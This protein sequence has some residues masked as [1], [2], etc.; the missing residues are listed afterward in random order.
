MWRFDYDHQLTPQRI[1][2]RP[3]GGLY[4]NARPVG[5]RGQEI[6]GDVKMRIAAFN[7]DMLKAVLIRQLEAVSVYQTFC[8]PADRETRVGIKAI[9]L[10][11]L[12]RAAVDEELDV[13]NRR[14]GR[15]R[16]QDL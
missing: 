8:T 4:S 6:G 16:R 9:D 11:G 13:L 3:V 15:R 2:R 14:S 1:V 12:C 10:G 7:I 5:I